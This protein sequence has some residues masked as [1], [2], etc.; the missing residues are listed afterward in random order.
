[1]FVSLSLH[2]ISQAVAGLPSIFLVDRVGV[3]RSDMYIYVKTE[4]ESRPRLKILQKD[5][6]DE[7]RAVLM[8]KADGIYVPSPLGSPSDLNASILCRFWRQLD[9]LDGCCILGYIRY[10]RWTRNR[11][12]PILHAAR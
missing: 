1:M 3:T 7:I 8:K 10:S 2:V 6:K 9:R 4:L 11:L 5:F 12:G